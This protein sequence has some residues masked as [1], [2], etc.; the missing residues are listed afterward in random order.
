MGGLEDVG[1][2]TLAPHSPDFQLEPTRTGIRRPFIV[3]RTGNDWGSGKMTVSAQLIV[4]HVP[5]VQAWALGF[6][7][8]R[9]VS[10]QGLLLYLNGRLSGPEGAMA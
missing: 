4:V 8:C 3:H 10:T 1:V 7:R 9:A 5:V 2:C 6:G